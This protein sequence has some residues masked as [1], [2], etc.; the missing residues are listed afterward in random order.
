MSIGFGRRV[1]AGAADAGGRIDWMRLVVVELF[2]VPGRRLGGHG[3]ALTPAAGVLPPLAGGRQEKMGRGQGAHDGGG[4]AACGGVAA[5]Q[6][7]DDGSGH[8]QDQAR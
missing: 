2:P 7:D 8:E 1:E 3:R 4:Q 6:V 5:A